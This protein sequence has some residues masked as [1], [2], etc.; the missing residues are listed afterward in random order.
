MFFFFL[1][2][3]ANLSRKYKPIKKRTNNSKK[4]YNKTRT[5]KK[6]KFLLLLAVQMNF[7]MGQ[8]KKFN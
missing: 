8:T 2:N 5:Y 1:Y 6:L 3:F 4:Q 7:K